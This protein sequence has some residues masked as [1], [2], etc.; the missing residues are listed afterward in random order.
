MSDAIMVIRV[1]EEF[2]SRVEPPFDKSWDDLTKLRWH[3]AVT[4]YDSGLDVRVE[5]AV[6]RRREFGRW[7][8]VTGMFN[9]RCGG[10]SVGPNTYHAAVDVMTGIGIGVR[11]SGRNNEEAVDDA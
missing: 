8:D 6:V 4:A 10:T 7:I 3:A 1:Q 5:I 2:G 11:E 9:V